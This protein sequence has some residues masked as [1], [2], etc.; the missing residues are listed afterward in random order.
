MAKTIPSVATKAQAARDMRLAM[1]DADREW[2]TA[3]LVESRADT[4]RTSSRSSESAELR[5]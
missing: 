5:V 1:I 2:E 3:D 4:S